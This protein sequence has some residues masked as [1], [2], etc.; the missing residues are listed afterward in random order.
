M[1]EERLETEL[2]AQLTSGAPG[3]FE[4]RDGRKRWIFYLESGQIL[5]TRS[6]LKSEGGD[7]IKAENPAADRTAL[8]RIQAS[9]RLINALQSAEPSW[10]FTEKPSSSKRMA[11]PTF[12]VFVD[13]LA[14]TQGLEHLRAL[15]SPILEGWPVADGDALIE[16]PGDEALEAYLNDIDGQRPGSEVVEFAPGGEARGLA[17]IWFA[18]K[19]GWVRLGEAPSSTSSAGGLDLGFDLDALIAEETSKDNR[20]QP[21]IA[22]IMPPSR[23]PAQAEPAQDGRVPDDETD[24]E[25][26]AQDGPEHPMAAR[27]EELAAQIREAENH[28]QVL[29]LDWEAPTED[30]SAAY[31]QLARDLHPDRYVSAGSRLELATEIFDKIRAAWEVIGDEAERK[32]YTDKAIHGLKTEEEL[33]MEHLQTYWAAE[34]DFKKGVAAYN[35]GK[36]RQAHEFFTGA[37]AGVPDEL[38]FRAYHAYTSFAMD[39]TTDLPRALEH[40]DTLKDVI[41]L[42]KEQERK[43]DMAWFLL[44]RAYRESEQVEKARRCFVQALRLNPSNSDATREMKRLTLTKQKQKQGFFSRLFGKK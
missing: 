42:N 19:L 7:V 10:N 35:Q 34:A 17:G 8:V 9:T 18:W 22:S 3:E 5:L 21:S 28:F 43:L 44:G 4:V 27:L 29:G 40:L 13:A 6:N 20:P 38:E 23:P 24:D 33:A 30:F 36:I 16:I 39:R 25:E 12:L 37:V 41:E 32:K 31:L 26:S 11:I 14:G 2:A 1:A 15:V